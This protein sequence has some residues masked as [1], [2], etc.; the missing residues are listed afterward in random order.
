MATTSR[1]SSGTR[2]TGK[3]SPKQ[4]SR[5]TSSPVLRWIRTLL[6]PSTRIDRS[7]DSDLTASAD[8]APGSALRRELAGIALLLFAL[9]LVGALAA[10]GVR[11]LGG[12]ADVR[13]NF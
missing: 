6:S 13:S 8:A 9:F 7:P 1:K 5:K 10:V 3:R 4:A 2:P 12:D 11:L